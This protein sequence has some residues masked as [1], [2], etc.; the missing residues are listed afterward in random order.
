[1]IAAWTPDF[2]DTVQTQE[3]EGLEVATLQLNTRDEKAVGG[4]EDN[5]PR[6]SSGAD[7]QPELTQAPQQQLVAAHPEHLDLR[8][9]IGAAHPEQSASSAVGNRRLQL[10]WDEWMSLPP[11]IPRENARTSR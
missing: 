3:G 9:V 7:L 2:G 5:T 6:A 10:V 4:P 1:M 8:Q 11:Y